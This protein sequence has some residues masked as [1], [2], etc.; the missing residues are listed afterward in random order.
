MEMSWL[1]RWTVQAIQL[2]LNKQTYK[3]M[4]ICTK[5]YRLLSFIVTFKGTNLNIF[6]SESQSKI[7]YSLGLPA[8]FSK[9]K[10]FGDRYMK[11]EQFIS[12]F[13]F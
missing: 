8:F 10:Y 7:S 9:G 13:A 4:K 2:G 5:C 1:L 6:L 11:I 12:I 3:I